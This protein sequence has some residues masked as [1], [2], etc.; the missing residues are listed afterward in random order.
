[1]TRQYWKHEKTGS[2]WYVELLC[3]AVTASTGP[4]YYDEISKSNLENAAYFDATAEGN[5]WMESEPFGLLEPP[6]PGD[7]ARP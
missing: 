3:G 7:E 6:Y 1:M 2:V 4:L 5:E